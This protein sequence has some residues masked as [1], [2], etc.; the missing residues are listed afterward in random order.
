MLFFPSPPP[1]DLPSL[2][3]FA[4]TALALAAGFLYLL[5]NAASRY[6][7]IGDDH[8]FEEARDRRMMANRAASASSSGGSGGVS[9]F[10]CGRG[11]SMRCSRCKIV[12]YC[13]KTCQAKHWQSEHKMKC[14]ILKSS[15]NIV[16]VQSANTHRRREFSHW[17]DNFSAI[18][19][20]PCGSCKVSQ[21][22][23]PYDEFAKLY[24][25][26]K[27]GFPPCG[28]QNH[29]NSC[30]ANVIL[31]CLSCTRP[32]VAYL[33][34][35]GHSQECYRTNCFLCE[36]Q[37][38][39][40]KVSQSLHPF[41]PSNVLLRLTNIDG[42]FG[43]GKQEDAHEFMRL[44]I[45]TMQS[46]C[47]DEFGGEKSLDP[48]TQETTLIQ[49]IFGGHLQSQIICTMCNKI[50]NRYENMMDLTVEI[51]GDGGS[52]EECLNKFTMKEWLDGE[53]MYKCDGCNEY[54]KAL[55][56]LTIHQAPNI[57]T[58]ALKRFQSGRFGKLNKRVTYPEKLDLCPYMSEAGNGDVYTLYAVVVHVDMLNSS[59]FGHYI[60]YTKDFYGNWYRIDDCM[61]S[62]VEMEEVLAQGAYM[63]LY[64]RD[65]V[66]QPFIKPIQS[67]EKKECQ[68]VE[69]AREAV[70]C[71][72]ESTESSSISGSIESKNS[73]C[74]SSNSFLETIDAHQ[75]NPIEISQPMIGVGHKSDLLN[76]IDPG[77]VPEDSKDTES[78]EKEDVLIKVDP[79][80][81]RRELEGMHSAEL[82]IKVNSETIKE[83]PDDIKMDDTVTH[84]ADDPS[85][86]NLNDG[87]PSNVISF[88]GDDKIQPGEPWK[89]SCG[90]CHSEGKSGSMSNHGFHLEESNS[91]NNL[92]SELAS[93]STSLNCLGSETE[94]L[95]EMQNGCVSSEKDIPS[96][97]RE[98]TK[99]SA[100]RSGD[101]L[102]PVFGT[103]FLDKTPPGKKPLNGNKRTKTGD[104]EFLSSGECN[105]TSG[106]VF[107]SQSNGHIDEESDHHLECERPV[108]L[109]GYLDKTC[110]TSSNGVEILKETGGDNL[111]SKSNINGE[112]HSY[113]GK[114]SNLPTQC[115]EPLSS[116]HIID[117]SMSGEESSKES[118]TADEEM[119][120]VHR[121]CSVEVN[122]NGSSGFMY[123][124]GCGIIEQ[125]LGLSSSP[126]NDTKKPL[127]FRG[128]LDKTP[129][130]KLLTQDE[131]RCTS[132]RNGFLEANISGGGGNKIH[133]LDRREDCCE[134]ES[135]I[136]INC[137]KHRQEVC[138]G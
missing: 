103:G 39:I 42:N 94:V 6:F 30:Y 138:R 58:I 88:G 85:H 105:G 15:K 8:A 46:V 59:F 115:E 130:A 117:G 99:A 52:L 19:L 41:S 92:D 74:V 134:S 13:S 44:A 18:K 76:K 131:K 132:E 91:S 127:F 83:N 81:V 48:S 100:F 22:L 106:S 14:N 11:G 4:L 26:D 7:V 2:L 28:L 33:L 135:G 101:R 123:K 20:V 38:H 65:S 129:K 40:Q 122:C 79:E 66:R 75:E 32:L 61:V 108:I 77:S 136:H 60:C 102:K 43:Y 109:P 36:L 86:T 78:V 112:I 133:N 107:T 93:S 16:P 116:S 64:S 35:R 126:S 89:S 119:G 70:K 53:N 12:F 114:I 54:V 17:G 67:T 69:V 27:L 31:Q 82:M 95:G 62:K 71:S 120:E 23:F 111:S 96:N 113:A 34:G 50:S 104:G 10:V 87:V 25:W 63:L 137:K 45:D 80:N 1:L 5:R 125:R 49:Y 98:E 24:N 47:L 21:I 73:Q 9:C 110:I 90:N 29:G 128:F 51:Q 37:S 68:L 3:R 118:P 57:L 84:A 72:T 121:P 124:N 97:T 55:K 56:R